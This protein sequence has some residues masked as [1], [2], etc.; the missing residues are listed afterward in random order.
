VS[1]R[2]FAPVLTGE[3]KAKTFSFSLKG[4]EVE[5]LQDALE[6]IGQSTV[7]VQPDG[8]TSLYGTQYGERQFFAHAVR[9]VILAI[10][11]SGKFHHLSEVEFRPGTD[12]E[13]DERIDRQRHHAKRKKSAFMEFWRSDRFNLV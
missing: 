13:L 11:R 6:V 1:A 4:P 3:T 9:L 7:F 2:K 10:L 5:Q 12:D 8:T